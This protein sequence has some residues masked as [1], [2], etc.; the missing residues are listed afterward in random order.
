MTTPAEISQELMNVSA[1]IRNFADKANQRHSTL[2]ARLDELQQSL[3][4]GVSAP[5]SPNAG[6]SIGE[7]FVEAKADDLA[8]I[9]R[10]KGRVSLG[11]EASLTTGGSSAGDLIVPNRA[12]PVLLPRRRLTVRDLLTVERVEAGGSVDVPKQT[13][14]TN[15][16]APVAEGAAKPESD[17]A[18]DLESIPFRVIA[19]WQKASKQVL[20]DV[21]RLKALI[22]GELLYGLAVVEEAQLLFGDG[23]GQNIE[24]MVAQATAFSAPFIPDDLQ[25]MIDTIGL[26]INQAA[27]TDLPPDGVVLHPSDWWRMRLLKDD[28]GNYILGDPLSPVPPNLFGLPVVPTQAMTVDKFLVGAFKAQTLFDRWEARVDVGFVNDDFTKNLVTVLAEERVGLAVRYP[29]SL[30]YGDFGND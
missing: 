28:D 15:S 22:D 4:R 12:E 29:D 23:T 14:R 16:A 2:E 26:A 8:R 19:H 3:I 6:P 24:G 17:L 21:P 18:F 7:Q 27:L 11:V 20:D 5:G 25:T 10:E 30:I 9:A 13:T 1:S